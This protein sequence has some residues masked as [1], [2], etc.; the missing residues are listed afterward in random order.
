M[1]GNR[2]ATQPL[3][4]Y[5]VGD[6]AL[7]AEAV[8]GITGWIGERTWSADGVTW[9]SKVKPHKWQGARANHHLASYL[10]GVISASKQG[11]AYLA[12]PSHEVSTL[13]ALITIDAVQE[14]MGRLDGNQLIAKANSEG[15]REAKAVK[16][17]GAV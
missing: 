6:L 3:T 5:R 14:G 13:K 15:G 12:D 7:W 17:A 4:Q 1:K 8:T 2:M 11:R 9:T 10:I 16:M